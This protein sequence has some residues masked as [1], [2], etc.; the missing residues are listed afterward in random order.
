[1]LLQFILSKMAEIWHTVRKDRSGGRRIII[2]VKIHDTGPAKSNEP[3][4]RV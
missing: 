2:I 4:A 3:S 1:M